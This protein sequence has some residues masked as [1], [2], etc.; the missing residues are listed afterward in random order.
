MKS[1]NEVTLRIA[2]I[3]EWHA[4]LIILENIVQFLY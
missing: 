4:I 1:R 3:S 2:D